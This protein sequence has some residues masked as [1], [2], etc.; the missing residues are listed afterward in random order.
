MLPCSF[1]L[2]DDLPSSQTGEPSKR[3]AFV[4]AGNTPNLLLVERENLVA[5]ETARFLNDRTCSVSSG[6]RVDLGIMMRQT[7]N[8]T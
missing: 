5:I 2:R 3:G 1:C 4:R 8:V 6:P 7:C